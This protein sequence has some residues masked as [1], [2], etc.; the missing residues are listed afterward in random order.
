M[1]RLSTAAHAV[2][3]P[4]F[5]DA[6]TGIDDLLFAGEEGVALGT[7]FDV[8]FLVQR[9][10]GGERVAATADNFDVLVIGMDVSFHLWT[11]GTGQQDLKTSGQVY[12]I[13]Y[14]RTRYLWTRRWSAGIAAIQ[15]RLPVRALVSRNTLCSAA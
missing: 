13:A 9:G 3:A 7:H 15:N 2:L 1:R 12:R 11:P 14:V 10:S 4:E 6:P 8:K 5:V